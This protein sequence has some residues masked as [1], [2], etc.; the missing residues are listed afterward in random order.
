MGTL[1]R[2]L[3][4]GVE[5]ATV[6]EL[7]KNHYKTGRTQNFDYEFKEVFLDQMNYSFIVFDAFLKNWTELIVDFYSDVRE[8]D[9]F[10]IKISLDFQTKVIFGYE[11]TTLG[12]AKLAV[13]KNGNVVR[14]IYQKLNLEKD[15][16]EMK[17]NFGHRFLNEAGFKYPV[18]GGD[19]SGFKVLDFDDIQTLFQDAGFTG[20]KRSNKVKEYIHLEYHKN[21]HTKN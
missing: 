9:E 5:S 14:S 18:I 6:V 12:D 8:H 11:Q 15:L 1:S 20:E 3:I 10:L 2:I 16:I 4:Q 13:W 7:L 19:C 17:E 21:K